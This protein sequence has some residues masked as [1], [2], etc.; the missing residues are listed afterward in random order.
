[1]P[2]FKEFG[3]Q[4]LEDSEYRGFI[5]DQKRKR[6]FRNSEEA[7]EFLNSITGAL[8]RRPLELEVV[9]DSHLE[10]YFTSKV[11]RFRSSP[12]PPSIEVYLCSLATLRQKQSS[13]FLE[14]GLGE[15]GTQ[16]HCT[17]EGSMVL[18]SKQKGRQCRVVLSDIAGHPAGSAD[19]LLSDQYLV[20]TASLQKCLYLVMASAKGV[21]LLKVLENPF[22]LKLA[23]RFGWRLLP[24]SVVVSGARLYVLTQR[25][26]LLC[27]SLDSGA[28]NPLP[29]T[30]GRNICR[31]ALGPQYLYAVTHQ[32]QLLVFESS[33]E[34]VL[35]YRLGVQVRHLAVLS[36]GAR[37]SWLRI[38]G[39]EHD[40][41]AIVG[42]NLASEEAC[43]YEAANLP[44][45]AQPKVHYLPGCGTAVLYDAHSIVLVDRP[46]RRVYCLRNRD[47]VHQL[48]RDLVVTVGAAELAIFDVGG[49]A[50]TLSAQ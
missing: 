43:V 18:Y 16:L 23:K 12:I 40:R 34:T 50:Q 19:I 26:C 47:H 41:P 39:G 29:E 48:Q 14:V 17:R 11:S 24:E 9:D 36:E 20:Q 25:G 21:N 32:H 49:S 44:Q 8:R 33:H 35:A 28:E 42:V 13:T 31:F 1:M 6:Y 10:E 7:R 22:S 4:E 30:V 3:S 15:E 5:Y 46:A 37:E 27:Y 38:E 2:R 45:M